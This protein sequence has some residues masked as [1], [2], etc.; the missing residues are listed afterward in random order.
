MDS[1]IGVFTSFIA[2]SALAV[3]V[4]NRARTAQVLTALLGGVADLQRAAVSPVT[5]K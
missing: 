2:L 5:G 4:S 1:V 3:A